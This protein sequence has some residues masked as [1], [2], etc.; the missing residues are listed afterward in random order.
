MNG[1]L[2]GLAAVVCVTVMAGYVCPR[3]GDKGGIYGFRNYVRFSVRT[4]NDC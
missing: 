4:G 1:L 3:F 2:S